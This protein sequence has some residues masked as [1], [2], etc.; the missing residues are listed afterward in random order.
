M[1]TT[2]SN[3]IVTGC[4]KGGLHS[5]ILLIYQDN[6]HGKDMRPAAIVQAIDNLLSSGLSI[7]Q[8]VVHDTESLAL[9]DAL[10]IVVAATPEK[11]ERSLTPSQSTTP[12]SPA[13]TGRATPGGAAP[14][15]PAG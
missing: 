15:R 1:A 14:E 10:P 11:P 9:P 13:H 5:G 7:R 3:F 2:S 8:S 12:G 6:R 4:G